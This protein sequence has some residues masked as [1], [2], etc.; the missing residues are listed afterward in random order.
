M[1]RK[2]IIEQARTE[3]GKIETFTILAAM[4]GMLQTVGEIAY[5][6]RAMNRHISRLTIANHIADSQPIT[7]R[8]ADHYLKILGY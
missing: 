8:T 4:A 6:Q 2:T 7:V 1:A 3:S 5:Q